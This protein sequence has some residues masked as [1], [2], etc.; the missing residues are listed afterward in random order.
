[1]KTLAEKY[2]I[3][4][5]KLTTATN[6]IESTMS[7]LKIPEK[8]RLNFKNAVLYEMQQLVDDTGRE[9]ID[10]ALD[11]LS[12]QYVDFNRSLESSSEIEKV[13]AV[14]GPQYAQLNDDQLLKVLEARFDK[15][16][17][18]SLALK[19]LKTRAQTKEKPTGGGNLPHVQDPLTDNM[20]KIINNNV[21]RLE[22]R[23]AE[24]YQQ[25]Q[26]AQDAEI[27]ARNAA[28][29]LKLEV[30][31]AKGEMQ[32]IDHIYR[33]DALTAIE[34]LKKKYRVDT[35]TRISGRIPYSR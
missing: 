32:D 28:T 12:D 23:A 4:N 11:E 18:R 6:E 9:M 5:G 19:Y 33:R 10:L 17:E 14:Y 26:A 35:G 8:D 15:P 1:M 21:S 34:N 29:A 22:G 16:G 27:F 13:A 20:N 24:K 31:K 30:K 25:L 7:N 2:S 3:T